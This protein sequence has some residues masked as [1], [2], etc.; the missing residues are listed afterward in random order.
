[1]PAG[2]P[3]KIG[4]AFGD[5]FTGVYGTTAVL[6]A[7]RQREMTGR[8]QHIDMALLDSL[9]GVLANQ[10]MNYLVGTHIPRR[11][12]NAH[13]NIVPYQVFDVSDGQ[14]I[15]A[16][17]NDGQF[18]RL[19]EYLEDPDL[20]SDPAF[21][22]NSERVINRETLI[23]RISVLLAEQRRSDLL[24]AMD[25]RGIPA[26][27]IN[28]LA[29]VFADPQV[30]HRELVAQLNAPWAEGGHMPTLRT[31]IVF[32]D[33]KLQLKQPAPQLG[34]HTA[35]IRKVLGLDWAEPTSSRQAPEY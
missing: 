25:A 21:A 23:A 7:L 5:I 1:V 4:V 35:D 20:A 24:A 29:D 17:G 28:N 33:A 22:T 19:C 34:E 11:M 27:P 9:V 13:P 18:T 30:K 26:G 6:A 16:V 2:P 8:G 10:G 14:V 15:I 31:P 3:E 12:G 32:S